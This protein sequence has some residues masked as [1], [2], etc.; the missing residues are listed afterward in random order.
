MFF[1]TQ[2]RVNPKTD[3]LSFVYRLYEIHL[4]K[5]EKE[6]W[7]YWTRIPES[8]AEVNEHPDFYFIRTCIQERDELHVW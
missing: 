8:Q 6:V 1:K 3:K 5:D 2:T 7:H 4:E